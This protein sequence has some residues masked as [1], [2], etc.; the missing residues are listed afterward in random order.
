MLCRFQPNKICMCVQKLRCHVALQTW[1]SKTHFRNTIL[2]QANHNLTTTHF[3]R[4]KYSNI[5]TAWIARKHIS[6]SDRIL[7]H[8]PYYRIPPRLLVFHFVEHK[9]SNTNH[10]MT[11]ITPTHKWSNLQS[12]GLLQ[13]NLDCLKQICLNSV[14]QCILR[15]HVVSIH[16]PKLQETATFGCII[17]SNWTY[18]VQC[19]LQ[20][21]FPH[22]EFNRCRPKIP[23][24]M[25]VL[26]LPRNR[27]HKKIREACW[28]PSRDSS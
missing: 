1:P 2:P 25:E 3:N 6:E 14:L 28:S 16:A 26:I 10:A 21:D 23:P 12:P 18:P 11:L 8:I 24:W 17:R 19:F 22:S 15:H 5:N 7:V 9:W 20:F 27:R 4:C 13:S